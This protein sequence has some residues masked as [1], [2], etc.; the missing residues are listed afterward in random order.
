MQKHW[1]AGLIGGLWNLDVCV[2][3]GEGASHQ[4]YPDNRHL[5]SERV[6]AFTFQ[7]CPCP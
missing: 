1:R 4:V 5:A 7:P 2:R 3:C 6:P